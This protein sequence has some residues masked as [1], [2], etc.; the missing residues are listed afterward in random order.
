MSRTLE[1]IFVANPITTNQSLD[2]MY[3]SRSPYTPGNDTGMT[4]SNFAAQF[5]APFTPAALTK[6]NDTNVTMTLGGTPST[7]LLQSVS[8]TMGWTGTLS[9]TRGG[10]GINNGASTAT[11]AGNL[12]FASSFTTSG[13][14]AVTQT[15]TGITNVTFPT[16][17]T[18][19]TTSQ[20][21]IPAALTK[22]DDTNVTLTLGGTPT[23]ALL[24]AVSITAGWTGLLAINRGGTNVSSVTIVPTATSFAGW[25]AN[26]NLSANNFLLGTQIITA[27]GATTTLAVGSPGQTIFVG[28]TFQTAKM[29]VVSTLAN[30]TPYRIINDTNN[31]IFVISSGS[32]AIVTMQPLT[33][34]LLTFNGTAATDATSWDVQY[35]SNTIGVQSVTGTANQ[36]ATTSATGNITLSLVSNPILPGTAGVT[37]P[38]G[39]TAARGGSAGTMRFNSQTSVFEV[40]VDGSAW[41]TLE[42]SSTGVTSVSGTTNRI[43]STG[44]T[45]PVID[46]AATYV[47]QSSITTLGTITTGV[48][49]GTAIDLAAHVSGNL[50]VTNLNSGSGAS[51]TTYWSGAGTWTTPA[52]S[53]IP[54]GTVMLFAQTAAPTGWTKNV[55]TN[56]NSA[57]RVVTGTAGTGG[58]VAF[59]TAFAS[60]SVSGTNSGYTLTT[61]DIPS[62]QHTGGASAGTAI[63]TGVNAT[64]LSA[65]TQ[66]T[67]A[68][69]GGGSH[70]HTFTGTAINMA[71]QYVDVIQAS[72]N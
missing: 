70:T 29:P 45:T 34:T 33:Q 57:L 40:T 3:F 5:G 28:S 25:D 23:T 13:A 39:N 42:T 17:G 18:L 11:Y 55:S 35:T 27:A 1:Q 24:Q 66:N 16:S 48:W 62:H 65:P 61:T 26:S 56:D 12:N 53:A 60:Q 8:M 64:V 52:G 54:S 41:T 38:S 50:P 58:S 51:A 21:P 14:F 63:T 46:I 31:A 72:K 2:L 47:G 36:I 20:L 4:F 68:T 7:A 10:T 67:G 71:V 19:A 43:T 30:G 44:G 49:N 6:T 22:G 37:L 59:T 15:Y 9:G 69:G 32:N